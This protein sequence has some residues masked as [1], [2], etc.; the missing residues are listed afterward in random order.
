MADPS[1]FRYR[2]RFCKTDAMR[3][4]GN[5]DLYR[6]WERTLRR[7]GVPLAYSLGFSPHPKINLGAALALGCTSEAE[8]G[9]I[10]LEQ[11]LEPADL[12]ASLQE[13]SAPG[14]QITAVERMAP[15]EPALQTLIRSAEYEV[16]LNPGQVPK[17]LTTR[18]EALLGA[19]QLPRERRGKGYDLRPLVEELEIVS[20]ESGEGFLRIRLAAREGATGRPEEVLRALGLEPTQAQVHRRR[21]LLVEG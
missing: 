5:L 15:N 2:V 7:A 16:R 20:D 1:L 6:T 8:L 13:A 9:E 17:D 14:L 19:P 18:V 12:L 3:Y 21:L 4:T 10:W 11:S